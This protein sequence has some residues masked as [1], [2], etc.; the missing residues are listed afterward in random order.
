VRDRRGARGCRRDDGLGALFGEQVAQVVC[1]V[2]FVGEK[3]PDRAGTF[4]QLGCDG[5]V[6]DIAGRQNEDARPAF[7][8]RERM[9]LAGLAAARFAERLLEGP[10]FPPLAERCALMCVLSIAA[11]P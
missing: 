6:V 7:C 1:V 9:E 2:G 11:S 4:D 10:P 8:V 3:A 5:D